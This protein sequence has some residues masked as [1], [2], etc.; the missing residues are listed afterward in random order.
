MEK[1]VSS[2]LLEDPRN[3]MGYYLVRVETSPEELAKLGNLK[4]VSGMPLEAYIKTSDPHARLLLH[5][6]ADGPDVP[7]AALKTGRTRRSAG[8]HRPT[9]MGRGGAGTRGRVPAAPSET[10]AC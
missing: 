6:A 9:A 8:P 1:T 7:R 4:L 2:D 3:G 10:V 5:Q